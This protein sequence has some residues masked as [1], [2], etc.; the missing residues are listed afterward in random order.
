[1]QLQ[2]EGLEERIDMR[3]M[4]NEIMNIIILHIASETLIFLKKEQSFQ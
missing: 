3:K 2:R 1:M 4:S